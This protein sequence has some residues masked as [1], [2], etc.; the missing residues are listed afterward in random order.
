MHDDVLEHLRRSDHQAPAEAQVAACSST[1][2]SGCAGR[3]CRSAR[4]RRRAHAPHRAA[5]Q[6]DPSSRLSPVPALD[7]PGRRTGDPRLRGRPRRR[8]GSP[9][10]GRG[11]RGSSRS[12]RAIQARCSARKRSSWRSRSGRGT[13]ASTLPLWPTVTRSRRARA[14][15]RTRDAD[16]LAVDREQAWSPLHRADASPRRSDGSSGSGRSSSVRT[17]RES[18]QTRSPAVTIFIRTASQWGQRSTSPAAR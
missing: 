2:P 11:V 9:A 17:P 15:S 12:L 7:A 3:G 8:R 4:T 18:I 13:T 6:A 14:D 16:R 1:S 10:R 5:D